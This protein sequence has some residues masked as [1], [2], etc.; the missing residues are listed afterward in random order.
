MTDYE[1]I[2]DECYQVLQELQ[3]DLYKS[4]TNKPS[5]DVL[6][7]LSRL[8]AKIT[9]KRRTDREEKRRNFEKSSLYSLGV[10]QRPRETEVS[11]GTSPERPKRIK[12][13]YIKVL[14]EVFSPDCLNEV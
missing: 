1:N 8:V 3:S 4:K 12:P 7:E 5:V 6:V 10:P 14:N 9:E 2:E 13:Y 11:I